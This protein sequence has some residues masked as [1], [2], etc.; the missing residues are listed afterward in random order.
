MITKW[1]TITSIS[2]AKIILLLQKQKNLTVY[3]LQYLSSEIASVF[4]GKSIS[5]SWIVKVWFCLLGPNLMHCYTR[6]LAIQGLS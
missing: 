5:V 1:P 2:N 4:A 6:I 3:F